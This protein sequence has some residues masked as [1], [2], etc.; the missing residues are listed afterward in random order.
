MP[1]YEYKAVDADASCSYCKGVFEERQSILSDSLTECPKCGNKIV[2]LVSRPGGIVMRGRQMNQYNDCLVSKYWRDQNGVR[3]KVG[4]GDGHSNSP[5]VPKRKTASPAQVEARIQQDK[6]V[7]KK[8][9]SEDS[10]RRYI[11]QAKRAKK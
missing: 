9:R 1:F 5:T 8:Q 4:L 11:Q 7:A 2:R 3:H 10:Y 6:K